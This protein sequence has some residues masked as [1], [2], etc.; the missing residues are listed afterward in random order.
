M[1]IKN[2]KITLIIIMVLPFALIVIVEIFA[3]YYLEIGNTTLFIS[4]P[5]IEYM[6][7]PNQLV[8]HRNSSVVVNHYGMRTINF[9]A[10]KNSPQELRVMVFGDS[11]I[12]GGD[13][14]DHYALATTILHQQLESRESNSVVGNISAGS[15][16][17][18]NWLAYIKEYGVFNADVIVLIISSH[19]V[20]DNPKFQPLKYD[21]PTAKPV[22]ASWIALRTLFDWVMGEIYNNLSNATIANNAYLAQEAVAAMRDLNHFLTI[23]QQRAK[24]VIVLQHWERDEILGKPYPGLLRI[25]QECQK[26]GINPISLAPYFREAIKNGINPFFDQIHLNQTGQKLLAQIIWEQ[27][28][29][30]LRPLK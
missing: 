13:G 20:A 26:L 16:G 21:T 29:S 18:G 30:R 1:K 15:W 19:D 5:T 14:T 23:A 4:H 6:L 28:Q 3:R 2:R 17:P 12:N 7:R 27:L 9:P 8:E 24:E 10:I 25:T 11:V 22:V